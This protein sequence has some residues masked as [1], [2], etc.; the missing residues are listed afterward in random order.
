[1]RSKL[2]GAAVAAVICAVWAG[3]AEAT[4]TTSI[5]VAS[6]IANLSANLLTMKG[7][8]NEPLF[9]YYTFDH[10]DI[11]F[12]LNQIG[13]VSSPYYG[14]YELTLSAS[15]GH[16][17]LPPP[18]FDPYSENFLADAN[19]AADLHLI[20]KQDISSLRGEHT[21]F[22]SD[23]YEASFTGFEYM[24]YMGVPNFNPAL[25]FDESDN[26]VLTTVS[27]VPL[28]GSIL[29]FASSILL[30]GSISFALRLVH[31]P[32]GNAPTGDPGKRLVPSA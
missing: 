2:S 5:Q 9:I 21:F 1:M 17:W 16:G 18:D 27:P 4:A 26:F 8:I 15:E 25:N 20:F 13:D 32:K 24:D 7:V 31:G 29:L 14:K 30:L 6:P 28:P 12:T 23:F 22:P 19:A 11:S 3:S 10:A